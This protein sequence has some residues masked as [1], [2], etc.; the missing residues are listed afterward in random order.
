MRNMMI[1]PVMIALSTTAYAA[2]A[3][4]GGVSEA[5]RAEVVKLCPKS[6]DR[7]ARRACMMEKRAQVSEGCRAEIKAAREGR[8]AAKAAQQSTTTAPTPEK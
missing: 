2:P 7:Q 3:A 8:R 4:T 1:L 5:C 6:D